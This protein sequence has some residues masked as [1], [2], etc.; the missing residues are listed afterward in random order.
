MKRLLYTILCMFFLIGCDAPEDDRRPNGGPIPSSVEVCEECEHIG[1]KYDFAD[2]DFIDY[3][4]LKLQPV[5]EIDG[6][7]KAHIWQLQSTV[8]YSLCSQQPFNHSINAIAQPT[9]E[10]HIYADKTLWGVEAGE[11]I[12]EHFAVKGIGIYDYPVTLEGEVD[13]TKDLTWG[14]DIWDVSDVLCPKYM[15]PMEIRFI[16]KEMPAE[17]YDEV[18]FSVYL[19]TGDGKEFTASTVVVFTQ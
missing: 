2:Y 1:M 9:E 11:P 7:K 3:L 5:R 19:R 8:R 18:T 6:G 15:L 10:I 13:F 14:S 12:E 17:R 4:Q 16:V